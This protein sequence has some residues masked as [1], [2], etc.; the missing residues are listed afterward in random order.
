MAGLPDPGVEFDVTNTVLVVT[1]P[2]IDF[3]SPDGVMWDAAEAM[4]RAGS[5]TGST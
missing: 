1:D 2:Q 5:G 3:L 4:N